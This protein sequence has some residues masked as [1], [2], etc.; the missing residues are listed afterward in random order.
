ML[1]HSKVFTYSEDL[2]TNDRSPTTSLGIRAAT[3]AMPLPAEVSLANHH[4]PLHPTSAFHPPRLKRQYPALVTP[5]QGQTIA[6]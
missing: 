5:G 2:L 4:S 1:S 6:N 3:N